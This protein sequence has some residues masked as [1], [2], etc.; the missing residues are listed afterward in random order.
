MIQDAYS[1]VNARIGIATSD[2]RYKVSLFID[3]A[4]DEFYSIFATRNS[5]GVLTTEAPPRVYG[6]TFEV[7]Y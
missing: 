7:K 2:D 3:N 6:V 1:I 4:F 5:L